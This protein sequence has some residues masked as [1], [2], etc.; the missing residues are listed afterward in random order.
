MPQ[1]YLDLMKKC[2]TDIIHISD[3][4]TRC[5][6]IENTSERS[7]QEKFRISVAEKILPQDVRLVESVRTF[8]FN[9]DDLTLDQIKKRREVGTDWPLRAH[10]MIGLKRLDN[11]QYCMETVIQD[12]ILGDVIETGVWRGGS[13]IFMR[14]V[15]KAYN[16][17]RTV[18]VADSFA[19]LPTSDAQYPIDSEFDDMA[20]EPL[21]ITR[22]TVEDNF[23]TYGLLDDQVQ[24]LEGWFKDTLPSAPIDSLSVLRLDG[25]MYES[26]IQA[27]EALYDKVSPGGFVI[28]DDYNLEACRLAIKD[29]RDAHNITEDIIDIDGIGVYWRKSI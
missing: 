29:Y 21:A 11:L 6:L 14:A 2:L 5:R 20:M 17:K 1:L 18:W 25:D 12:A 13:V 7:P 22:A 10:T 9:Y 16:E 24:F 15:L 4:L 26:T 28:V 23:R 27:L 3:D 19:G 8:W